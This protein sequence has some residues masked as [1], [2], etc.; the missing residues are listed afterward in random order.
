[1]NYKINFLKRTLASVLLFHLAAQVVKIVNLVG[2]KKVFQ[3]N[4]NG[5]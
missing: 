5:E 4:K 2:Y 3:S 1:M